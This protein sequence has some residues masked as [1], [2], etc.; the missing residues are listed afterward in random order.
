MLA[1]CLIKIG[2][3]GIETESHV[4]DL[5]EAVGEIVVL[6]RT[7]KNVR[8]CTVHV[9]AG[10]ACRFK[11]HVHLIKQMLLNLHLNAAEVT[12]GRGRIEIRLQSNATEAV[13]EVHDDGPGIPKKRR[14][15]RSQRRI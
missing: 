7:H 6:A 13:V 15:N 8:N 3:K 14:M 4:F 5:G 12:K 10:P 11:E 2:R 9:E 1:K